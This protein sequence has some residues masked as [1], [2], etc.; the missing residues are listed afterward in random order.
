M[1]SGLRHVFGNASIGSAWEDVAKESAWRFVRSGA[2]LALWEGNRNPPGHVLTAWEAWNAYGF[3]VLEEAIE[4]GSAILMESKNATETALLRCREGLGVDAATV[5][6]VAGVTEQEVLTAETNSGKLPIQTLEKIAFGLGLDERFLSFKEDCGGD[7]GLVSQLSAMQKL[8]SDDPTWISS[9]MAAVFAEA[10]SVI[11]VQNRL[12]GWLGLETGRFRVSDYSVRMP[13]Q[14]RP[15]GYYIAETARKFLGLDDSP[16]QSMRDLV[17]QQ[18]GIPI[19][20]AELAAGVAGAT[21]SHTDG[22]GTEVRGVVMNSVGQN[23]DPWVCRVNLARGLGYLLF[24]PAG[25][26]SKV[27]MVGHLLESGGTGTGNVVEEKADA[28]ALAFLAPMEAVRFYA[29]LPLE[30]RH[31]NDVM[32]RF[33]MSELAARRRIIS[34]YSGEVESVPQARPGVMASKGQAES[35]RLT[36]NVGIPCVTKESRGGQFSNIVMGSYSKALISEHTAA[37]YLGCSVAELDNREP[38]VES[39]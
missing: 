37:L 8:P 4:Y 26:T 11:R 12:Q 28:F 20:Q 29:P 34:C 32:R 7:S 10:A 16:I 18:L 25:Q 6:D 19:V 1:T 15:A 3:G 27:H 9:G 39:G 21:M 22:S 24:D 35:E 30:S 13:D 38:T 17:G 36:L 23:E 33:G 31:V 5:A 14:H 2:Q